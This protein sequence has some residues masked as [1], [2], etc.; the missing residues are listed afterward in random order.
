LEFVNIRRVIFGGN[1]ERQEGSALK[2]VLRMI[3]IVLPVFIFGCGSSTTPDYPTSLAATLGAGRVYLSW[4]PAS[5]GTG[6]NVYRGFTS[7]PVSS[8]AKIASNLSE[9]AYTDASATVGTN[10][11]YQVTA[12][13]GNGETRA[14]NEVLGTP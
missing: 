9:T 3:L 6:Y 13:N 2:K 10:Y 5:G 4:S 14:S 11:Y 7:G 1:P 12:I 8:K